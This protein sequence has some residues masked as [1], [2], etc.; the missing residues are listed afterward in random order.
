MRYE[1]LSTRARL[2]QLEDVNAR[3]RE[4][5]DRLNHS[6]GEQFRRESERADRLIEKQNEIL[7]SRLG[8]NQAP[9]VAHTGTEGPKSIPRRGN[10]G[11]IRHEYETKKRQEYWTKVIEANEARR[12][13]TKA[14]DASEQSEN[15]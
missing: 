14:T 6:L 2:E 12:P 1:L 15:K 3:L 8:L 5:I 13:A 9:P 10:F 7:D 4:E 11:K